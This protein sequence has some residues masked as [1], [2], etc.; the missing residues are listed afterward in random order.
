MNTQY[1]IWDTDGT[2]LASRE[3]FSPRHPGTYVWPMPEAEGFYSVLQAG[4]MPPVECE[5]TLPSDVEY[6]GCFEDHALDLASVSETLELSKEDQGMTV[7]V[8]LRWRRAATAGESSNPRPVP[9]YAA[10]GE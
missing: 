6:V 4:P 9:S 8:S 5:S 3:E 2:E 10:E 7:E 1:R